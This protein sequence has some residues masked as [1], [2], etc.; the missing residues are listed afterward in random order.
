[1]MAMMMTTTPMMTVIINVND[2]NNYHNSNNGIATCASPPPLM[3][4]ISL[5]RFQM[6]TSNDWRTTPLPMCNTTRPIFF[7]AAPSWPS[8]VA[9]LQGAHFLKVRLWD[10][11]SSYPKPTATWHNI[12]QTTSWRQLHA[13][14]RLQETLRLHTELQ[15]WPLASAILRALELQATTAR[16]PWLPQTH[17]RELTNLDGA[18][19]TLGKYSTNIDFRLNLSDSSAWRAAKAAWM[20]LATTAQPVHQK[21]ATLQDITSAINF[22]QDDEMRV[23]LMLLWLSCGRK[24]D[25]AKLNTAG[26]TLHA[27]GRLDFF[28]QEGK[29]VLARRGKYHVTSHCPT[30]WREELGNFLRWPRRGPRL[31]RPSMAVSNEA[32][33]ALREANPGLNCRSVRRGA[34]QCIAASNNV[35]EETLMRMSGHRNVHTLHRYLDW[36]RIN[37]RAHSLAQDAARNL[38]A[39]MPIM[40]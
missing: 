3:E 2:N 9:A 19:A 37:E 34:L 33:D 7:H 14:H 16:V 26:V 8:G 30:E 10:G 4:R 18:F 40:A 20:R 12:Q 39:Q 24:G 13:L 32:L 27:D 11:Q 36:D 23:F 15:S 6:P 28:I 38:S 5:P 1:M 29:G 22:S 21:A 17:F 35:T 31:F 25:V